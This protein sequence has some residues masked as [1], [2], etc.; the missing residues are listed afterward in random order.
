MSIPRSGQFTV[1][2]ASSLS[3]S[4]LLMVTVAVLSISPQVVASVSDVMCTV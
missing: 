2:D 4:P 1:I 3:P